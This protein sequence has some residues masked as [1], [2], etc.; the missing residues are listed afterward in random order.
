M[1]ELGIINQLIRSIT[2]EAKKNKIKKIKKVVIELGSLTSYKKEPISFY[3]DSLKLDHNLIKESVLTIKEINGKVKCN[4]CKKESDLKDPYLIY[5]DKCESH[6]VEIIQ[7]KDFL[8][9]EIIG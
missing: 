4:K 9:K 8:I 5:C 1:H 7:G 3:F 2:E 6:D